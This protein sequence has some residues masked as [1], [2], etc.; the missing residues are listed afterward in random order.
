MLFVFLVKVVLR[1]GVCFFSDCVQK[2]FGVICQFGNKVLLQVRLKFKLIFE[3]VLLL[4]DFGVLVGFSCQVLSFVV[5]GLL[6]ILLCSFGYL[7]IISLVS[8]LFVLVL[9]KFRSVGELD[10]V[11]LYR[12]VRCYWNFFLFFQYLLLLLVYRLMIGLSMIEFFGWYDSFVLMVQLLIGMLVLMLYIIWF[13]WYFQVGVVVKVFG[14][15]MVICN[16][17]NLL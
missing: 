17:G 6:L 1:F 14:L 11:K 12:F 5:S 7:M 3:E 4:W 15:R 8:K 2:M 9:L 16:D 13:F 10:G